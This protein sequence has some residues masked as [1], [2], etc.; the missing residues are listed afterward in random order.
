MARLFPM[1]FIA[2]ASPLLAAD[3][4]F[5]PV[6]QNGTGGY[7]AYR[8][9]AIVQAANGDL[10]AFCEAREGGDASKIDLVMKR[11]TDEGKSWSQLQ[12]V[13]AADDFKSLFGE[14]PPP[15]TAGNPAP[16]V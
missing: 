3:Y 10:L 13:Q 16:V 2:F 5:V 1:L 14:N 15:I 9:P 6:F 7:N 4:E 12:V 8:I 11:S